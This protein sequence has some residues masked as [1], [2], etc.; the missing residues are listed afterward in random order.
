M[1]PSLHEGGG[2]HLLCF[3]KNK[4]FK[5]QKM[6]ISHGRHHLKKLGHNRYHECL[7][8]HQAKVRTDSHTVKILTWKT[9]GY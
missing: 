6:S 1:V 2:M 8:V 5:P 7:G 4:T 3:V 9:E